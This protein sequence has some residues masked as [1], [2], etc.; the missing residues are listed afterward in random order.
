MPF[1]DSGVWCHHLGLCSLSFPGWSTWLGHD[2]C[3]SKDPGCL[4]VKSR[5]W[6]RLLGALSLVSSQVGMKLL[7]GQWIRVK[8]GRGAAKDSLLD[9]RGRWQERDSVS[10]CQS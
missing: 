4:L 10:V 7:D 5:S 3:C 2:L 9:K 1:S 8:A 6:G